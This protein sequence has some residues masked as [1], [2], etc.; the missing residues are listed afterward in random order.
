MDRDQLVARKTAVQN[1]MAQLK[2]NAEQF[3]ANVN[4]QLNQGDG[5]VAELDELIAAMEA[6]APADITVPEAE[7]VEE[8]AH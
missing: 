6:E 7:V 3:V 8:T 2:A 4:M 5:R 1:Q